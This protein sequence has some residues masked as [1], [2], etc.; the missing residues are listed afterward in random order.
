MEAVAEPS[1]EAA[2][3]A[4]VVREQASEIE[5]VT[6]AEA[7]AD[8]ASSKHMRNRADETFLADACLCS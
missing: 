3:A 7:A 8:S 6:P 5:K 2:K 1:S 4:V